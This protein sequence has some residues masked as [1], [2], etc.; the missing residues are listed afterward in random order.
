MLRKLLGSRLYNTWPRYKNISFIALYVASRKIEFLFLGI[1][2]AVAW[3]SV[4]N[5]SE[6]MRT[7]ILS[8]VC[9][10]GMLSIVLVLYNRYSLEARKLPEGEAVDWKFM[11][12]LK[13]YVPAFRN[14]GIPYREFS[15]DD[16]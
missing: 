12:Y 11:F 1:I 4:V 8:F 14:F 5:Q 16:F 15:A 7:P 6:N 10:A 2:S 13:K 9:G 3:K